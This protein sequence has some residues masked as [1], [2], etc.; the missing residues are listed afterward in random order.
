MVT[1]IVYRDPHSFGHMFSTLYTLPK[2]VLPYRSPIKLLDFPY[3]NL[4]LKVVKSLAHSCTVGKEQNLHWDPDLLNSR[5]KTFAILP[6]CLRKLFKMI[7]PLPT[8]MTLKAEFE[9]A[10]HLGGRMTSDQRSHGLLMHHNSA[11]NEV[12]LLA[13]GPQ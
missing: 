5:V 10:Y 7:I 8:E 3:A 1:F 12:V 11:A 9:V 6:P 2:W 13:P 4:K